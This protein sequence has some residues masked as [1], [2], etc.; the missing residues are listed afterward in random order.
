MPTRWCSKGSCPEPDH[1]TIVSLKEVAAADWD[2]CSQWGAEGEDAANPF[3][4]HAFLSALE[5]SGSVGARAGWTSAH[6]V[7]EADGRVV[8]VAPC[9]LKA[10]SQGEYVFDH[11]WADAYQRAGGRYYPKLQVSAPFTPAQGRRLMAAPDVDRAQIESALAEGLIALRDQ[12]GASSVHIT[13][14]EEGEW[15]RMD[16]RWL[17]RH[18]IQYHWFNRGFGSYDDFLATLASRKRKAL[19]RER[20][21]A[22]ANGITIER[23]TG[24]ELTEAV[25]DAFF[26]FYMDTGSR[27]WGRPYLNRRF[28]SLVGQSMADSIV[29]VMA[30]RA[31]RYI[32]GAIN[33]EGADTLYGRHWGCI[34]DHPF[35]HFE[36]CY[37]QAIDHAIARGLSRVEAGAQGEHKIARGYEPVLTRSS[38]AIAHSGLARAVADFLAAEREHIMQAQE[39]LKDELPFAKGRESGEE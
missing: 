4:R 10:N 18:D 23:L 22:V 1:R 26:A 17:R 8:G 34:E 33:F 7:A 31:G 35:L 20:R 2:R 13:F 19:K 9:Y 30:Q 28:F 27:K 25:W 5:E 14:Q 15:S 29:L 3:M 6:L 21:D 24:A 12:T 38:H 37:H 36:C 32:A 39:A 11:A 16:G